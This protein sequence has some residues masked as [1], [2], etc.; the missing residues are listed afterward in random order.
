[1]IARAIAN[2]D[3]EFAATRWSDAL[4]WSGL[5]QSWGGMRFGNR[6]VDS[7]TRTVNAPVESAFTP[8]RRIGGRNGWY[9]GS[10]LWRIRG[11]IDLLFGG[12]GL[13]RGR[14]DPEYLQ[15]GDAL[16]FW[17]VEEF[18]D[19]R[20]LRLRAE[21]NLPG[22]AWLEFQVERHAEATLIRQTAIFDPLGLA[23]LAS[24]YALYPF[25]KR[26][27]GR[28]LRGIVNA[29]TAMPAKI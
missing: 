14:R 16:D 24:W 9:Y 17:R 18:E 22:P 1:M 28:M 19:N 26:I 15:V 29:A 27:F 5:G 20:T 4:S 21:M 13:R 12:I 2:E 11:F 23:G 3:R 8:I 10:R 25:H 6:S 7:T